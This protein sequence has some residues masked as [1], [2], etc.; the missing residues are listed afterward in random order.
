M[1]RVFMWGEYVEMDAPAPNGKMT[2]TKLIDNS[3]LTHNKN[4]LESPVRVL[5][6][7]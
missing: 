4:D 5:V 7:S 1:Q 3:T 6:L 2:K